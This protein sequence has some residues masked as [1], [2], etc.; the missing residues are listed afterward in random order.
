MIDYSQVLESTKVQYQLYKSNHELFAQWVKTRKHKF[1]LTANQ[2]SIMQMIPSGK[3]L[4][5]D[6]FG[7]AL[8]S[9]NIISVEERK[10]QKVFGSFFPNMYFKD[11]IFSKETC[12][13]LN[14]LVAPLSVVIYFSPAFKYLTEDDLCQRL[15]NLKSNFPNSKIIVGIDT[16][17]IDFNKIKWSVNSVINR[18]SIATNSSIINLDDTRIIIQC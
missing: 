14:K 8:G 2:S 12:K 18:I 3:S 5:L 11:D 6:S 4:W 1:T 10:Y 7:F 9:K 17:F 15:N 13:L 16:I